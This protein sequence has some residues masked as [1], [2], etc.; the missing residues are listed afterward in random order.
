[1][2]LLI[3]R[4][5]QLAAEAWQDA[6]AKFTDAADAYVEFSTVFDAY[7]DHASG[8][9]EVALGVEEQAKFDF[10]GAVQAFQRAAVMLEGLVED[11]G[12]ALEGEA[13]EVVVAVLRRLQEEVPIAVAEAEGLADQASYQ[14]ST[15]S[16]DYDAAAEA[17]ESYRDR[18]NGSLESL[19]PGV[20]EDIRR[21]LEMSC[22]RAE[23]D[24]YFA[25][26]RSLRGQRE[27]DESLAMY[28]RARK[29]LR[30]AA[31]RALRSGLPNARV[32]QET[33][34]SQVATTIGPAVRDLQEER[35][36]RD[37]LAAREKESDELRN[38][39]IARL[40][41]QQ[42]VNVT[43]DT[44]VQVDARLTAM[45]QQ[46]QHTEVSVRT[47][48]GD[49]AA[50]LAASAGDSAERK[51]LSEEAAQLAETDEKGQGFLEKAG[52]FVK[53]VAGI[54]TDAEKAAGPIGKALGTLAKL[55]PLIL[56]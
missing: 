14:A 6:S 47:E 32:I 54:V 36:L 7:A 43:T 50:A 9:R 28:E 49:L 3:D 25:R 20:T 24:A 22:A 19:P 15:A 42:N 51:Q 53:K 56:L 52:G 1:V 39:V 30:E 5:P 48:L 11:L 34:M 31:K 44:N 23:A 17:A 40:E 2:S 4:N 18:L 26:A 13:D 41:G 35:Q 21:L 16:G 12:T 55:L 27:W 8:E 38:A 29:A 33:L 45:Q 46:L 37:Q 10:E